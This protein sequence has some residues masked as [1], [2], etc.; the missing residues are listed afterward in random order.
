[1]FPYFHLVQLQPPPENLVMTV[2]H[3][4]KLGPVSPCL[5][6]Q[7]SSSFLSHIRLER[8]SKFLLL[9][10]LPLLLLLILS[11]PSLLL[12]PFSSF[13]LPSPCQFVESLE[14]GRLAEQ[15]CPLPNSAAPTGPPVE[16]NPLLGLDDPPNCR[17]LLA[18]TAK[19]HPPSS[20][21]AG[22]LLIPGPPPDERPP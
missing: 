11:S 18:Q 16:S 15:T 21:S 9:V 20:L 13:L 4:S 17:R 19:H 10:P 2:P 6:S 5:L 14:S 8:E 7:L 1:M 12:I 22:A 3:S